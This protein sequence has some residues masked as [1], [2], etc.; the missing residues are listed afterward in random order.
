MG[1]QELNIWQF[2][3]VYLL[4][5][6]ILFIM[7][8]MKMNQS[9]L[10]LIASIRMTL[11]LMIA[12]VVLQIIFAYP[13]PA[14]TIAYLIVITAFSIHRMLANS[15]TLNKKFKFIAALSLVF[16]AFF[17]LIFFVCGIVGEDFFNPQYTITLSGMIVGNAMTGMSLA[18]QGFTDEMRNKRGQIESLLNL[19]VH[20]KD[21]LRPFIVKALTGALLP[22]LNSML[23]MGIIFLP[24][25]MTGQILSGTMPTTAIM[26]QIAMMISICT[27][28]ALSSFCAL[29]FGHKTLYDDSMCIQIPQ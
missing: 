21:I 16:V 13:Y 26:Y 18:L 10:L 9:K 11:Q 2:L 23:G 5:I 28:V 17:I 25:M 22:T 15:K 6:I 29:Y 20:P 27:A 12:G 7:Q 1:A 24:G 19:G 8:K 4:L 14:L 3:A